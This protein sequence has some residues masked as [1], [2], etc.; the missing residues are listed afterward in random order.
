MSLSAKVQKLLDDKCGTLT[1]TGTETQRLF[2]GAHQQQHDTGIAGQENLKRFA[3][4]KYVSLFESK[5][6]RAHADALDILEVCNTWDDLRSIPPYVD[7]LLRPFA[8]DIN[9]KV[10]ELAGAFKLSR[11]AKDVMALYTLLKNDFDH[12]AELKVMSKRR[13]RVFKILWSAMAFLLGL[14]VKKIF[15]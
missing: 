6:M 11:E 15:L 1:I 2:E 5:I 10:G 13:D 9:Q 4:I 12:R 7:S 8:V 3:A 14:L